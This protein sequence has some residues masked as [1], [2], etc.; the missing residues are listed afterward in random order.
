MLQERR[1]NVDATTPESICM[2]QHGTTL[3]GGS[4][5]TRV[6]TRAESSRLTPRCAGRTST[7][8]VSSCAATRC[9]HPAI[10]ACDD[11]RAGSQNVVGL[12]LGRPRSDRVCLGRASGR[13][14]LRCVRL[15]QLRATAGKTSEGTHGGLDPPSGIFQLT[16]A[17]HK[18]CA[19]AGRRTGIGW[20]AALTVA[21]VHYGARGGDS[22]I[23]GTRYLPTG[24]PPNV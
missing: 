14:V 8:A 2:F 19:V 23:A 11:A 12:P 22:P 10:A 6:P 17:I 21:T 5:L 16:S 20:S 24:T 4:E 18:E 15:I 9:G 7:H 13:Q 1:T 3:I